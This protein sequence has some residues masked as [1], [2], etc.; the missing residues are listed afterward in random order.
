MKR[1]DKRK[2]HYIYKITRIFDDKFYIGMHSTDN[3]EDGYFGS[4]KLLWHSINKHGKDKHRKE[5]LEYLP[6]RK[7][8]SAKEKE[9]VNIELLEDKR[10]MNLIVGGEGNLSHVRKLPTYRDQLE[11]AGRNG[12]FANR[13][14]WSDEL[15]QQVSIK[16][17]QTGRKTKQKQWSNDTIK[18]LSFIVKAGECAQEQNAQ[19]KRKQTMFERH[20][21][22]GEK[23][24]S[25]GTCWVV[26]EGIKPFKI[27]KE[28]L[29]EYLLN[30]YSRGR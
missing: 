1:A 10:C 26:K 21:Q 2:Y 23:N 30:G 22:Q 27:K 19:I 4:G 20:H 15:K 18:M 5:I 28:Q 25:Y 3:L 16:L 8:L 24:S 9:I 11:K 12:G 7:S 29:D 17:S 6:D 13:H 14:L